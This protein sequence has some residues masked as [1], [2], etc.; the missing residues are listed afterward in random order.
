LEEEYNLVI[1]LQNEKLA[2]RKITAKFD[3]NEKPEKILSILQ[4][5]LSFKYFIENDTINIK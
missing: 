3:A 2:N 1:H 5:S 4:S